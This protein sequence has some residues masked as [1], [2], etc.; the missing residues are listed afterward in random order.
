MKTATADSGP[1]YE[2][3]RDIDIGPRTLKRGS[4]ISMQELERLAPGKSGPLRRTGIVRL[5]GETDRER[6]QLKRD[7][8]K[9]Y[10]HRAA[11]SDNARLAQF[12]SKQEVVDES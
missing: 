3:R 12:R 2:V 6:L 10:L 4:H 1:L 8:R 11:Q 9:E 7:E 5:V